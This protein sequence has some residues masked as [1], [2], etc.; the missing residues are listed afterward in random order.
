MLVDHTNER[1]LDVLEGR[2]KD[3]IVNYLRANQ[4]GL[5]AQLEEVTTDMWD[6]NNPLA[7]LALQR[8]DSSDGTH[9]IIA[10]YIY[11]VGRISTNT[12]G[13]NY[14]YH[15]DDYQ[16][17]RYADRDRPL[18]RRD[19]QRVGQ[20]AGHQ[21]CELVVHPVAGARRERAGGRPGLEA[22]VEERA[23]RLGRALVA[24]QPGAEGQ[25]VVLRGAPAGR[26]G[27]RQ[28]R[29]RSTDRRQQ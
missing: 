5:L 14:Y 22:Q 13:A 16:P 19:D 29:P 24:L 17:R 11:G 23:Q 25:P 15:Y 18:R 20:Q 3:L 21:A 1:V 10:R 28:T 2:D 4:G 26:P 8:D 9:A 7:Q 12:A 27:D 6:E